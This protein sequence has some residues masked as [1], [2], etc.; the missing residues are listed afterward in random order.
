M[1]VILRLKALDHAGLSEDPTIRQSQFITWT[2]TELHVSLISAT[3]PILRPFMS[4]LS[5]NY[6]AGQGPGGSQYGTGTT[7]SHGYSAL[8][9]RVKHTSDAGFELRSI[10]AKTTR[11]SKQPGPTRQE[12]LPTAPENICVCN[13]SSVKDFD[14]SST[15]SNDSQKMIIR[16]DITWE[17]KRNSSSQ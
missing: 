9:S 3:T 7:E 14:A 2:S 5:T 13:P 8:G 4:N 16:K 17:V 15:G 1:I 11:L 12:P 6:G 10:P